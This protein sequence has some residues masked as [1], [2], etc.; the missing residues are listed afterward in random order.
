[1]LR[2]DGVYGFTNVSCPSKAGTAT[3][4]QWSWDAKS[5][6]LSL[7]FVLVVLVY[8]YPLRMVTSSGLE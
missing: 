4:L 3:H 2:S 5:T 7:A 1:M 8:V 6:V